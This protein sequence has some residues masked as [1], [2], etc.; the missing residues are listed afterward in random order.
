MRAE[1]A[2]PQITPRDQASTVLGII[3]GAGPSLQEWDMPASACLAPRGGE[4][5][6]GWRSPISTVQKGEL[7]IILSNKPACGKRGWGRTANPSVLQGMPPPLG[8]VS[9]ITD[10][11]NTAIS[12]FLVNDTLAVYTQLPQILR[13]AE[14]KDLV[15]E[16]SPAQPFPCQGPA[17]W[18]SSK[19]YG[20][21]FFMDPPWV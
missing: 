20:F 10:D 17:L 21:I 6:W 11:R 9:P 16:H 2:D 3:A 8:L 13:K 14:L 19:T 12:L 7:V 1:Y 4:E 15:L 18:R 5:K